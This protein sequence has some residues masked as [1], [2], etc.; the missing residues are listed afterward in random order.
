MKIINKKTIELSWNVIYLVD[1]AAQ[2]QPSSCFSLFPL[3]HFPVVLI[4]IVA[5]L[6]RESG[7][8]LSIGDQGPV[9]FLIPFPVPLKMKEDVMSF[10]P[11]LK[12]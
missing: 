10:K 7:R 6:G 12:C 1:N 3:V 5:L 9:H 8:E 2:L 11:N 4:V